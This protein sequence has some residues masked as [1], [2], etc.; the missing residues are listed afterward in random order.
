MSCQDCQKRDIDSE[1]FFMRLAFFSIL[2][3]AVS[4]VAA[5]YIQNAASLKE[6]ENIEAN[7]RDSVMQ[8]N[9]MLSKCRRCLLNEPL[10]DSFSLNFTTERNGGN[11]S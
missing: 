4:I 7:C 8:A 3:L 9:A 2:I 5:G 11:D 6:R 10:I 1:R